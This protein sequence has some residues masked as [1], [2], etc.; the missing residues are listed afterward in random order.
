MTECSERKILKM[1]DSECQMKIPQHISLYIPAASTPS[2]PQLISS[3]IPAASTPSIPQL[4]ASFLPDVSTPSIPKPQAG[5]WCSGNGFLVDQAQ[6]MGNGVRVM[7]RP[8][9][10][11]WEY[12]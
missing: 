4:I 3:Y 9:G 2:I 5:E 1:T 12:P 10:R 8:M 6:G 7:G 11:P